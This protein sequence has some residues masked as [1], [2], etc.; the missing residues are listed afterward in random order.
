[1]SDVSRLIQPDGIMKKTQSQVKNIWMITREF[2]EL[3]GAGGVKDVSA[4]LSRALARWTGRKVY[5]VLPLYGV[6]DPDA[7]NLNPLKDPDRPEENLCFSVEMNYVGVERSEE[8][9]VWE[10]RLGRVQIYFLDGIRFREKQDIYTYTRDEELRNPDKRHGEGHYDYFAMNILLQKGALQLMLLLQ[11]K[12]DVIHCHDGHT[13]VLPAII[14]ETP[15]LNS[16][17]KNTGCLVTIHNAGRGYHQEVADLPFAKEM[18]GLPWRAINRCKLGGSFDPL[19]AAGLYGIVNTVSENYAKELQETSDDERTDWLGHHFLDSGVTLEGITNGI[20][21]AMYDT[22]ND[23]ELG[24][25]ASYDPRDPSTAAG[26]SQCK[27]DLK[28]R[29]SQGAIHHGLVQYGFL[30]SGRD[31]PLFT[32]IGRLIEQKGVDILIKG[33]RETIRNGMDVQMVILGSGGVE[34][35]NELIAMAQSSDFQGNICFINGFLPAMANMIYSGGDFFLIPSR[36][37]PCGLTD[38][39]AQLFGNLPVVHKVGGLVKVI[40][41]QTGFSYEGESPQKLIEAMKRAADAFED[42]KLIQQMQKNGVELIHEKYTWKMVM[43]KYLK[44]YKKAILL[45]RERQYNP[46]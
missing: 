8:V 29:L 24:I 13:A 38:F 5:V 45:R 6:I 25:A 4:Q 30:E 40:D 44:L 12:P 46:L 15:W 26:K 27:R 35:E 9:A 32:F 11:Q 42:M 17:F 22:R 18:T 39:I 7:L 3:A 37:E 31:C 2:G 28:L 1:V 19:V 34:L 14:A 20:D 41:A 43:K 23:T 16:Y 36:F 10:M 21:P 33:F